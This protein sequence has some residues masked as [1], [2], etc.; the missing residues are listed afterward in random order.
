MTT[1]MWFEA[2]WRPLGDVE[3]GDLI[4]P[5]KRDSARRLQVIDVVRVE[6]VR[7]P[8]SNIVEVELADGSTTW[9]GR[10]TKFWIVRGAAG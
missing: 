10:A 5:D 8:G 3:V 1:V 9:G 2:D 7:R 4:H 6:K